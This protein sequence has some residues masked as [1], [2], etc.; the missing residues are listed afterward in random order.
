MTAEVKANYVIEEILI[1]VIDLI[2]NDNIYFPLIK[3]AHNK[4]DG[5]TR[6]D[7]VGRYIV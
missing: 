1:L 4:Y 6:K 5:R 2:Q 7:T 3:Y